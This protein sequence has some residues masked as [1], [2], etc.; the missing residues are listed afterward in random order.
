M[1]IKLGCGG[2]DL[3]CLHESMRLVLKA[4]DSVF[5]NEPVIT[6]TWEG[7][8]STGSFHYWLRALDFRKPPMNLEDCVNQLKSELGKD[9]D[10]VL[11]SDHIH[12]E[13]DPK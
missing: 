12:I 11:E 4:V 1:L 3:S 7:T 9:F 13:Y 8:H 10:V 6:S 2:V 5:P